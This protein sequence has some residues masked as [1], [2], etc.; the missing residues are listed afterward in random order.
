ML[1]LKKISA[2][3]FTYRHFARYRQILTV[4]FKYGFETILGPFQVEKYLESCFQLVSKKRRD[5]VSTCTRAERVRMALEELG[6]TF[7]KLGQAISMRPDFISIDLIGELAKLQDTVLPCSFSEIQE[8]IEAEFEKPLAEIF[9]TIERVPIASAS[10]GQVHKARLFDGREAAIKICRPGVEKLVAVD[11]GI[12][13]HLAS[14]M[15]KNVEE[16]TFI[17]PTAIVEEFGRTISRELDY[18]VEAGHMERFA[19]NFRDDPAIRIPA[20]Y[21]EFTTRRV[22]TMEFISGIKVSEIED[23]DRA[24]V[25]KK[26]VT[27]RGAE[28]VLRQIFEHGFFHADPHAGNIFILPDDVIAFLDFGMVGRVDQQSRE[29]FVDLIDTV[30]RHNVQGATRQLLKIT[31]WDKKPDTRQLE[32]DVA[33]FISR[34]LYNSLKDL[35]LHELVRDLIYLMGRY[36]LRIS[37]DIFLM[38]KSL[39]TIEGIARQLDPDFDMI[40]QA[41]PFVQQVKMAKLTPHRMA[42]DLLTF[43]GEL[44]SFLKR[45]P[46]DMLDI[47]RLIR[48]NKLSL[49]LDEQSLRRVERNRDKSANRIA[50][51]I[52]TAALVIGSAVVAGARIPPLIHGISL[53]GLSGLAVAA[54]L[55]IW[56]LMAVIT[57]GRL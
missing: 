20:V 22:L 43:S 6:P 23:L 45:V 44:I 19:E 40:D 30:I 21:R 29:D 32:K 4:L 38:M 12:I 26:A 24:G 51:A 28:V 54:F 39:A 15:E 25:D 16:I 5:L 17:R 2:T 56:L 10:I 18:N 9:E 53:F 52:I 46:A 35:D 31:L 3:G 13:Y 49:N 41:A 36:R 14:L 27:S 7:I 33:D 57:R 50:V 34:H 47:S 55:G 8:V 48:E 11:L 37:P 1:S 42:E